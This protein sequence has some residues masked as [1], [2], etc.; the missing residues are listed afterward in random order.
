MNNLINHITSKKSEELD[1]ANL[2][3]YHEENQKLMVSKK[4]L[5]RIVFI[6][7]SITEGWYDSDPNFFLKNNFINRG[8]SGQ[9]THHMLARFRPD[10]IK[11]NPKMIIINAGTNDIAGNT[12][13]VT[14]EMIIDNIYS[15]VDIAIRNNIDVSLSSILPVYKYPWNENVKN[16]PKIIS[17]INSNL[18]KFCKDNGLIYIDYYSSMVDKK[19]GLKSIY[20][21]DGVHPTRSGYKVMQKIIKTLIPG[22]K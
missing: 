2:S 21:Y 9:T 18:K 11:L 22:I 5:N 20:G 4:N 10:A 15:M 12:G 16:P 8:I 1:W 14:P 3:K 19:K 7:D 6:G 13:P 17:F